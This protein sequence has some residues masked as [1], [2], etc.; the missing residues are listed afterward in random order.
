MPGV[1]RELGASVAGAEIGR[2]LL[3]RSGGSSLVPELVHDHEAVVWI[4]R[5]DDL[6]DAP[7]RGREV[8]RRGRVEG[9]VGITEL[10]SGGPEGALHLGAGQRD[11][12]RDRGRRERR[13]R[14]KHR[15][16]GAEAA[17]REQNGQ[18]RAEDSQAHPGGQVNGRPPRRCQWR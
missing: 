7:G 13:G 2:K 18:Q 1:R 3:A 10:Q 5:Q 14:A 12:R 6:E 4:L 11:H 9:D 16:R 17:S 15:V 8:R